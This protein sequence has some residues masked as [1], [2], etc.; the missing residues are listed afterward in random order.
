MPQADNAATTHFVCE[1][2]VC[3]LCHASFAVQIDPPLDMRQP[4]PRC[5]V[6]DEKSWRTMPDPKAAL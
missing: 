2:R 6:G 3:W 1:E 5:G 4:C